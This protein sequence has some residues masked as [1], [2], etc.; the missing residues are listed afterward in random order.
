[1]RLDHVER[2]LENLQRDFPLQARISN[3][4]EL[5]QRTYT[6]ILR[7]WIFRSNPPSAQHFPEADCTG[8]C[9]VQCRGAGRLSVQRQR[10]LYPC[11]PWETPAYIC[12]VCRRCA[13]DPTFLEVIGTPGEPVPRLWRRH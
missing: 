8:R 12:D 4:P 13:R 3:E 10:N 6:Q 1:M 7:F 2:G 5:I 11:S 9:G